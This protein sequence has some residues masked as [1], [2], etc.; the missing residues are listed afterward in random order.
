MI[1]DIFKKKPPLPEPKKILTAATPEQELRWEEI[2][3]K[4]KLKIKAGYETLRKQAEKKRRR[5]KLAK[6][7]RK[8][9]R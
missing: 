4:N 7:S 8:K 6:A 5:L 9:S 1:R 3:K 2:K